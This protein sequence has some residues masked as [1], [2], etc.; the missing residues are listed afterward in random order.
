M[1]IWARTG[2]YDENL[3]G[4]G[5]A[6]CEPVEAHAIRAASNGKG[7]KKN[8]FLQMDEGIAKKK[9]RGP[10]QTN[11]PSMQLSL[12]TRGQSLWE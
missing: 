3:E 8:V 11:Y 9:H 7:C 5:W 2:G 4:R 12:R 6:R 1:D 10:D